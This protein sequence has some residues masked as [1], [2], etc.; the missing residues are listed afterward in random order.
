MI[1]FTLTH[2]NALLRGLEITSLYLQLIQE[3][4]VTYFLK[5]LYIRLIQRHTCS[6]FHDLSSIQ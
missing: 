2:S 5:S 4:S 6:L 1:Y 3:H